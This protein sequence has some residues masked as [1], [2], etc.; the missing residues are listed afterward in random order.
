VVSCS[1][2]ADSRGSEPLSRRDSRAS[3][4]PDS[5]SDHCVGAADS[6]ASGALRACLLRNLVEKGVEIALVVQSQ[7]R[8]SEFV[9]TVRAE[10]ARTVRRGRDFVVEPY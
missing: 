7:V 4:A 6:P 3:R 10:A 9:F 1:L 2:S 8:P 5:S